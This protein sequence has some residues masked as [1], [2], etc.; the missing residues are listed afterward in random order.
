MDE[1]PDSG[2]IRA[3]WTQHP[4]G[5][6]VR[7]GYGSRIRD[8]RE[9]LHLSQTEFGNT[10]G[11][12][13]GTVSDW[14]N[15]KTEPELGVALLI[16]NLC[17]DAERVAHW[18][19]TGEKRPAL[20][21][22]I[23]GIGS[24]EEQYHSLLLRFQAVVRELPLLVFELDGD[25]K[26]V[27]YSA[28]RAEDLYLPPAKFMGKRMQDVLPAVQGKTFQQVLSKVRQRDEA[29]GEVA[30]ELPVKDGSRSYVASLVLLPSQHVMVLVRRA[31]PVRKHELG[32]GK[33][34]GRD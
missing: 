16:A 31:K 9:A 30:Y 33:A 22:R 24:A 7:H 19:D 17:A 15:E 23:G 20:N 5:R 34:K 21:R 28:G 29:V 26:I 2:L 3:L 32:I 13:Q 1:H 4:E 8:V 6:A 27:S 18:I 14:E 25:D 12:R 11:V 10:L